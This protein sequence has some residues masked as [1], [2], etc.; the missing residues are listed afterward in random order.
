MLKSQVRAL[1]D[2]GR[3]KGLNLNMALFYL[4]DLGE[5]DGTALRAMVWIPTDDSYF[6][7]I[8]PHESYAFAGTPN[9]K[10]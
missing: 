1:L 10:P 2:A 3:L 5:I 4:A 8:H 9:G 6:T 7:E